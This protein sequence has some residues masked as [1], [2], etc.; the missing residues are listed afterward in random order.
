MFEPYT[1]FRRLD[2][3]SLGYLTL[4]AITELL[5]DHMIIYNQTN[6]ELLYRFIDSDQDGV[7]SY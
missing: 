4:D 6:V 1:V 5:D 7:L 3:N 2:Q